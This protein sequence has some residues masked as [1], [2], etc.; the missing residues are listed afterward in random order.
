MEKRKKIA[1]LIDYDNFNREKYFPVLFEELN[2]IG[3]ILIKYAF[4]SNLNDSTIKDK[5]IKHG[6][7]PMSQIAYTKGK[8]AVDIR[9][10]IEAMSLLE[11]D[12]ID[13][14]CLATSDSDFTPL[15]YELQKHNRYV[16]GAGDKANE[17]YKNSFNSFISVDKITSR[18][19]LKETDET[20][21]VFVNLVK[22]INRIIESNHDEKGFSDFSYVILTLKNQMKDFNPK[23]YGAKNKQVLPFFQNELKQYYQLNKQGTIYS[24]KIK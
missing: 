21:D 2:E 16:I 5:F 12:Y 14:I 23:N 24:I 1:V 18:P 19:S 17:T 8:N 20:K 11:K 7:E 6:I 9:M 4:Y 10:A 22:T 13:C 3:D 15:V